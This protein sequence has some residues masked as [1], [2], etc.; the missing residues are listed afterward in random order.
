MTRYMAGTLILLGLFGT[1]AQAE[2]DNSTSRDENPPTLD[3]KLLTL[4]SLSYA[5]AVYDTQT[6]FAAFERCR[7]G[8]FE[9]NPLMRPFVAHR[10]SAYAY[11]MGLTSLS[12]YGTY[13]LK[14]SGSRLWWVPIVA[15]TALHITAGIHNQKVNSPQLLR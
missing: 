6:T 11:S 3:G 4:I 2:D 7:G 1:H 12:V 15:T 10:S 14:K 5:A 8:C 13:R 9:A